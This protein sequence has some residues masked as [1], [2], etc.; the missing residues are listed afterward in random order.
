MSKKAGIIG[1]GF[2]VPEKV[3]TNHDLEKMVETTDEWI[4]TR[5]GISERR[6]A[7]KGTGVSEMAALA[8]E[9]ALQNA[10]ITAKEIDLLIVATTTP[11][12]PLPATSCI[13][14]EKIG[15][16]NAVCFDL[17]AACAGFVYALVT[18]EQFIKIGTYKTVLVVG[19]DLD[20]LDVA[21]PPAFGHP[22][23]QGEREIRM[24]NFHRQ[25]F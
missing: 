4:R 1:I 6:I 24:G 23:P 19:A 20:L 13:V 7:E 8:A 10:G 14:Q 21:P 5:T 9:R 3:L 12:M 16:V 22:L 15:A 11:D 17:A 18:A 25:H 2:Y